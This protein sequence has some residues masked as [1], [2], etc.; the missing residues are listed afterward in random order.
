MS[1]SGPLAGKRALVFGVASDDSIAWAI[2]QELA[3]HGATCI[4]GYQKRFLSRVLQLF[5]DKPWIEGYL[6]CDVGTEESVACFFEQ[7]RQK[8]PGGFDMM[9]HCI[10]FAPASALQDEVVRTTEADWNTALTVSAYSLVRLT[11][12]AMPDMRPDGAIVS[13]TYLGADRFVPGYRVMSAAKAALQELTRELAFTCG[14]EK[15]VRVNTISAGPIRTLAASGVPGFSMILDWMRHAAPLARNVSQQDVAKSAYFLLSDL[16]S[17]VT[18]QL[19]YVDAG[20]SIMGVPPDL[21]K[22]ALPGQAAKTTA[23]P[24]PHP[25]APAAAP[26]STPAAPRA[27]PLIFGKP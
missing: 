9:V 23:P 12:H 3:A 16:A 25:P 22:M 19:L 21:D 11:R 27:Q 13:L 5:K 2:A 15:G 18:G 17:G 14:R 20:Y 7:A 24:A 1:G 26:A 10:G 4:M 8:H 6:E